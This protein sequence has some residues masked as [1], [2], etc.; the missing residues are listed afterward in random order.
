MTATQLQD[1]GQGRYRV[2][3]DLSFDTVPDLWEQSKRVFAGAADN[4]LLIDL[5]GVRYFDSAGLALLVAW[6]RVAQSRTQSF[7]LTQVP[8]KLIELAKANNLLALFGLE[9]VPA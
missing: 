1:E 7:T 3:G 5:G 4:G 6:K 8:S 2:R 9:S